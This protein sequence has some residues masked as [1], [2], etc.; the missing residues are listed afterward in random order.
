MQTEK[1]NLIKVSTT[2]YEEENLIL[3]TNLTN[4]QIKKAIRPT[5][6][7]ERKSNTQIYDNETLLRLLKTQYPNNTV[8]MYS[9]IETLT[10]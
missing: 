1:I 9:E 8:L 10:I 7:K 6:L 3:V 5:V 4:A 2:A